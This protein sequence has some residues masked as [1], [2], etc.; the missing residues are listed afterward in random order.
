MRSRLEFYTWGRD[1]ATA[2]IVRELRQFI[3]SL[4]AEVTSIESGGQPRP[5]S[6]RSDMRGLES[7]LLAYDKAK[8]AYDAVSGLEPNNE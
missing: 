2:D 8:A 6:V 5:W 1:A 7:Y 3:A 4:S